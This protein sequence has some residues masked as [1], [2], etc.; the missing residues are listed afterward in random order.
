LGSTSRH[1]NQFFNHKL[2]SKLKL[3]LNSTNRLRAS[4]GLPLPRTPLFSDGA[5][6][7]IRGEKKILVT[8]KH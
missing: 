6:S 2:Y 3:N 5:L 8:A 4:R 1:G 7:I